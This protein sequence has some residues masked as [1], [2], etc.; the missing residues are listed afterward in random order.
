M[1][2]NIESTTKVV[3]VNGVAARIWEGQTDTGIK[4]QAF[5]TRIA[6][7]DE[8]KDLSY[9]DQRMQQLGITPELNII[10]PH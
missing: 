5:L 4:V 8:P 7:K 3:N 1:K 9:C 6:S 10:V 2:I